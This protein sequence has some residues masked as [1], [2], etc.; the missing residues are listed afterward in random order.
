MISVPIIYENQEIIIINKKQGIS[1]QG[2]EGV[3][4]PLDKML[5]AELGYPV[6]LVHRLD[7]ETEGL[8]IVAK[9]PAAAKKWTN[10]IGGKS[11]KKEYDALCIGVPREKKG[12]FSSALVEHGTEKSALTYY[13]V[14]KTWNAGGYVLSQIHL[15]LATGRM[16]QIRIHLA[17]AGF[18]VA[19]DDKY[20]N[21][22]ANRELKKLCGIKRLK[23]VSSR[24]TVPVDGRNAVFEIPCGFDSIFEKDE[25]KEK[26]EKAVD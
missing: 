18:P 3:S 7:K 1:V 4:R 13:E 6:Y 24:L 26:G 11:V 15:T 9:S 5:S 21:F 17:K 22:K 25:K 2:G 16:H 14:V 19:G 20:G 10:L 23:L 8:L 12:R